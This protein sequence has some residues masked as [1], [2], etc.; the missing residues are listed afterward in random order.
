M[1]ALIIDQEAKEKINNLEEPFKSIVTK[2]FREVKLGD[3]MVNTQT[4]G[5]A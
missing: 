5:L 2:D 3:I 4:E 1:R